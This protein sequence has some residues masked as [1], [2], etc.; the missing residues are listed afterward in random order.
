M[1][2]LLIENEMNGFSVTE[3]RDA[4][5]VLDGVTA[6]IDQARRKIYRQILKL[7]GEGFLTFTGKGRSKRY[8]ATDEMK[9]LA[10]KIKVRQDPNKNSNSS[11]Q[12][13]NYSM[14]KNEQ[15]HTKDELQVVLGEIDEFKSLIERFPSLSK[16]LQPQLSKARIQSAK[17]QGKINALSITLREIDLEGR[18]S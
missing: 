2:K 18:V 6:D 11:K 7:L 3:L 17:L 15:G 4:S 14:L 13:L 1:Y 16:Y 12:L 9:A 8:Y 5:L 10:I